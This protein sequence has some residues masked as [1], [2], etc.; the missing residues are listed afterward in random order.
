M[1][2]TIS[3]IIA[4]AVLP[5]ATIAQNATCQ[6][7][8][9]SVDPVTN[10][11]TIKTKLRPVTSVWQ[12]NKGSIRGISRG[13]EKF[14]GIQFSAHTHYPFPADLDISFEE[15][16]LITQGGKY[17]ARLNPFIEKLEKETFFVPSGS[18]LR[19]T[20]ED[21]TTVFL[22]TIEDFALRSRV[23]RPRWNSNG[24]PHF[25]VRVTA[26]LQY[27]LDARA[28]AVLMAKPAINM[29]VEIGGQYYGFG[30]R[31]QVWDPLTW[32]PKAN[33]A[34]QEVLNCVL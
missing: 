16:E 4:A 1:K 11:T 22:K 6:Y 7:D 13:D 27:A 15:T 17:D 18:T 5:G 10:V 28:L 25:R 30:D 33:H 3:L 8:E 34:I 23:D 12:S 2:S 24:T 21:R 26:D 32:S 20:L 19:V 29:R 9:E 14:L 31:R